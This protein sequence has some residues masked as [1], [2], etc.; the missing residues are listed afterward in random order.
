MDRVTA[1]QARGGGAGAIG[2]PLQQPRGEL[3]GHLVHVDA[4]RAAAP[5]RARQRLQRLEGR[6]PL[7]RLQR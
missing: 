3:G 1:L 4:Q 7:D 2:G 5:R 6:G